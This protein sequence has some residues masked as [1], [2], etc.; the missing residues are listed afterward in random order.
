ME[1]T[2]SKVHYDPSAAFKSPCSHKSSLALRSPNPLET[3]ASKLKKSMMRRVS[4]FLAD[5]RA[6]MCK[7]VSGDE[8]IGGECSDPPSVLFIESDLEDGERTPPEDSA[9]PSC[10]KSPFRTAKMSH[11]PVSYTHLTLPTIC[12]V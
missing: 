4:S 1:N 9:G 7:E 11:V 8:I 3:P 5:E 12:S 10:A 6:E 2:N